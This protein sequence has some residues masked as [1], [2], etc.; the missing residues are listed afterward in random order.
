MISTTASVIGSPRS[1]AGAGASEGNA[2]ALAHGH[3]GRFTR[4]LLASFVAS[5]TP[6]CAS[7]AGPRSPGRLSEITA[8]DLGSHHSA[9][10]DESPQ[11]TSGRQS[12]VAVRGTLAA[13][14]AMPTA[15]SLR[16]EGVT[17]LQ[18]DPVLHPTRVPGRHA[19]NERSSK[20]I[21]PL[22]SC[23]KHRTLR[24]EQQPVGRSVAG[25]GRTT[26]A[27]ARA[28]SN[29]GWMVNS[30]SSPSVRKGRMMAPAA[31]TP[32]RVL[33][34][35]CFPS[36]RVA[37]RQPSV[38]HQSVRRKAPKREANLEPLV[39]QPNTAPRGR[40]G[41]RNERRPGTDAQRWASAPGAHA[42]RGS[43]RRCAPGRASSHPAAHSSTAN[44]A[45]RSAGS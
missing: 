34:A 22:W 9:S 33:P 10:G 12:P 16:A 27:Q 44:C 23:I 38:S 36:R 15:R 2:D 32:N 3:S 18:A 5:S 30:R 24:A 11:H 1:R 25:P 13:S 28:A 41:P 45:C 7:L 19:H 14:R 4:T 26:R 35:E 40:P 8:A 21:A 31:T 20:S 6:A 39:P 42:T 17:T 29:V 37:I 43:R